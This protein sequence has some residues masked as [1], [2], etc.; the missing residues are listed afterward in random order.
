MLL[1]AALAEV[2]SLKGDSDYKPEDLFNEYAIKDQKN[3]K[4]TDKFRY[5]NAD[6]INGTISMN[7]IGQLFQK[8]HRIS[9]EEESHA[10]TKKE[11][12]G[13][14]ANKVIELAKEL[15]VF[16][17]VSKLPVP[18]E[19]TYDTHRLIFINV[20]FLSRRIYA[21]LCYRII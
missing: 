17:T 10:I 19:L 12:G 7:E 16:L 4:V 9:F 13:I 5:E 1:T 8:I 3:A 14:D 2:D 18:D 11:N 21:R 20:S 6:G 15:Y